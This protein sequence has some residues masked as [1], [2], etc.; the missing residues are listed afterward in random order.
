MVEPQPQADNASTFARL[1][2]ITQELRQKIEASFELRPDSAIEDLQNYSSSDGNVKG[3]LNAAF[4]L[5][6]ERLVHGWLG[7][8]EQSSFSTMRL[9]VWLGAHILVPHL[10][11]EFGALPDL[12]FYI[13]Y[14]PRSDLLVDLDSLDR[15]YE[16]INQSFLTLQADPLLS[17]FTSKSLY[18]RQFQSPVSLCYTCMATE[19][20]L[21]LIRT[22]SH[23][24]LDRWLTWVQ[25]AEPVAAAAQTALRNRD[26]FIR[27]TSAERDPGN[28]LAMQM[29][30]T[31]LTE[32]LIRG[33]W[34][35][36]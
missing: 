10:A 21:E 15:Y 34:D 17:P 29:F 14:I 4:G 26:L 5:P 24:M 33:L 7:N 20:T 19:E 11:F 6:I 12:F 9:T 13:D 23:E 22:V 35:T 25:E 16:P 31:E 28:K 27:R 3:S 32:K 36:Q 30:G 8:P 18:I 2:T 1:W